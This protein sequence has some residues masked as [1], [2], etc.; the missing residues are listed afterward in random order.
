MNRFFN[1]EN[2]FFQFLSR[3]AD[4]IIL[5]LLFL[6]TCIPIVT[7]GASRTALYYMTMKMIRNEETYIVRGYFKSFKENFKQATLMWLMVLAFSLILYF[8]FNISRSMTGM[9]GNV[10]QVAI[11]AIGLFLAIELLYLFPVLAKFYNSIKAT[12]RNA[13]LMSIRH[14]PQTFLMLVIHVGVIFLTLLNTT[15]LIYGSLIWI[16]MG[17]ALVALADSW[18]LVKIFDNYIPE[19]A[20]EGNTEEDPYSYQ[21]S[22][23]VFKNIGTPISKDEETVQSTTSEKTVQSTASEKTVQST[24][25]EKTVQSAENKKTVQSVENEDFA[26]DEESTEEKA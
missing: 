25:N 23:S 20:N 3:L 13:F 2:P 18:F 16:L 1:L 6:L 17:F 8:D 7:I 26:S 15:T 12:F 10:M 5:N 4:M 19:D 9:M 14:L 24:E 11:T 21:P 22:P